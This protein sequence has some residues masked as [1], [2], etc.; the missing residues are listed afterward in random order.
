MDW[1][2]GS[3]QRYTTN[4]GKML[5]RPDEIVNVREHCKMSEYLERSPLSKAKKHPDYRG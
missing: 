1:S 4:K 3:V 2:G 5:L